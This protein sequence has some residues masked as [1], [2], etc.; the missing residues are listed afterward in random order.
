MKKADPN[1]QATKDRE[2]RA[3]QTSNKTGHHK[4]LQTKVGHKPITTRW[5]RRDVEVYNL[6]PLWKAAFRLWEIKRGYQRTASNLE[7]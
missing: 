6:H 1:S 3:K 2:R 5:D 4:F 7:S